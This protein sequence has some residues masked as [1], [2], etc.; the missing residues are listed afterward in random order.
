MDLLISQHLIDREPLKI[1]ADADHILLY[2]YI[3]GWSVMNGMDISALFLFLL[4]VC[5]VG[6]AGDL[7]WGT[8]WNNNSNDGC[9]ENNKVVGGE[10]TCRYHDYHLLAASSLPAFETQWF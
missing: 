10:A 8:C 9:E 7:V 3:Y 1:V 5:F 4:G 2:I 6:A